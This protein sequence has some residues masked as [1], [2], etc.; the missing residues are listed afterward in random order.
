MRDLEEAEKMRWARKRAA[1]DLRSQ[2]ASRLVYELLSEELPSAP[3][4]DTVVST[5]RPRHTTVD[6]KKT[7]QKPPATKTW[8]DRTDQASALFQEIIEDYSS[9]LTRVDNDDEMAKSA[10]REKREMRANG[11]TAKQTGRDHSRDQNQDHSRD[12]SR[13]RQLH[14]RPFTDLVKMQRPELL[15]KNREHVRII[16]DLKAKEKRLKNSFEQSGT[17][18]TGLF[19]YLS[20]YKQLHY[21]STSLLHLHYTRMSLIFRPFFFLKFNKSSFS[22][23][24]ISVVCNHLGYLSTDISGINQ[25]SLFHLTLVSLSF[26]LVSCMPIL[27]NFNCV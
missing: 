27:F 9:F 13:D 19:L 2:D 23:F 10:L 17:L 4:V 18:T 8:T 6:R 11:E 5:Q 24:L 12:G 26:I 1:L 7:S 21:I 25:A 20:V 15:Q 16:R 22:Q 3:D 14:H